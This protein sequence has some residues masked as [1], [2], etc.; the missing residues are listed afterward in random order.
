MTSGQKLVDFF[1]SEYWDN[2]LRHLNNPDT[3]HVHVYI[4]TSIEPKDL[5]KAL[6]AYFDAKGMQSQRHIDHMAPRFGT[7]AL[8]GIHPKGLP[9]FDIMFNYKK[10]VVIEPMDPLE[11]EMGSNLKAWGKEYMTEYYKNFQFRPFDDAAKKALE[12]YFASA[13]FAKGLEHVMDEEN[14]HV[15]LN[16]ETSIDPLII[17]E[18]AEKE[19]AKRGFELEEAVD[20]VFCAK[21]AYYQGKV[22]FLSK[23]PERVF[24]ISWKF[25]PKVLIEPTADWIVFKDQKGHDV[26]TKTMLK[27]TVLDKGVWQGLSPQDIEYVRQNA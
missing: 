7:G 26:W 19:L 6:L 3:H 8:H 27:E 17:K 21:G 5:E 20:C 22:V 18:Y 12:Q 13:H 11:A 4:N 23:K 14:V 15:H 16:T 10:D 9:H 24:D 1:K 2:A 25:N